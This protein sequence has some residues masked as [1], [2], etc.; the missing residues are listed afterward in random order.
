MR[1]PA[2]DKACRRRSAGAG[3]RPLPDASTDPL[4][5]LKAVPEFFDLAGKDM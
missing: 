2:H 3:L 1:L 5:A 4:I